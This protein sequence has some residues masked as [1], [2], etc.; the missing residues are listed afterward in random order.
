MKLEPL[1]N[2]KKGMIIHDD[3]YRRVN[4]FLKE[5]VKSAATGL[6][7]NIRDR[8]LSLGLHDEQYIEICELIIEWFSDVLEVEKE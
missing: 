7:E 6:L 4:Y 8:K 3:K 1:N 2:K 5:D